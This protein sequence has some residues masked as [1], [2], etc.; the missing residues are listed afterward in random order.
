MVNWSV[1]LDRAGYGMEIL[2][3]LVAS[4]YVVS[5]LKE[6]TMW[7]S[8][9][10]DSTQFGGRENLVTDPVELSGR[11]LSRFLE[12]YLAHFWEFG[13]KM[14]RK[15]KPLGWLRFPVL[16]PLGIV[17]FLL[18]SVLAVFLLPLA[19]ARYLL[20]FDNDLRLRIIVATFALGI[21]LQ[22]VAALLAN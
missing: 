15:L 17:F 16:A 1:W 2:G 19:V 13:E 12:P 8:L 18:F 5:K 10:K 3:L 6:R 14:V 7:I 4:S 9:A 22:I 20:N 21:T 11:W